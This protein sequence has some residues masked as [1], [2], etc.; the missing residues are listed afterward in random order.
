VA[1]R[2]TDS[3]EADVTL[4]TPTRDRPLA[5]SYCERWVARQDFPG[6]V[7]W[8]VVDDGDAPIRTTLG[9]LHVRRKPS[10]AR[11][12]LP[13]NVL[14]AL[15][16]V[17]GAGLVVIEDDD[18]YHPAYVGE[19]VKR[20]KGGAEAVGTTDSL[21]YHVPS[22]RYHNHHQKE[23]ASFC[24]TAAAGKVGLRNLKESVLLLAGSDNPLVDMEFWSPRRTMRRDLFAGNHLVCGLKGWPGRR[25][26]CPSSSLGP[27]FPR[28][29]EGAVL[30]RWIGEEDAAA[31]LAEFSRLPW[32][33][34]EQQSTP[35]RGGRGLVIAAWGGPRRVPD[36]AYDA[37]RGR[38]LRLWADALTR[39]SHALD[40]VLVVVSN[41]PP[42]PKFEEG[43]EQV[44]AASPRARV[45]RRSNRGMSYGA[46]SDAFGLRGDADAAAA[47]QIDLWYLFED[48]WVPCLN[49]WDSE[50]ARVYASKPCAFMGSMVRTDGRFPDH[51]G[52]GWGLTSRDSLKRVWRAQGRLPHS[53]RA[54]YSSC[55]VQGNVGLYVAL[56]EAT[57]LPLRD[58]RGS[59]RSAYVKPWGE[60]EWSFTEQDR[61]IVLPA[62]AVQGDFLTPQAVARA[63]RGG[64]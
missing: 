59:Y 57:G 14:A 52:V 27:G 42:E 36:P 61:A 10:S 12:T 47:R 39:F 16:H 4:F 55:E 64:F 37:D 32:A 20:L 25:N 5:F 26:L 18:W 11:N 33:P 44:R 43:L 49:G 60:V 23:H 29:D 40:D 54:D 1:V 21:Y 53:P 34:E 6:T 9:Q 2:I 41:G 24:S 45:L 63:E 8:V 28:D 17:V 30:A 15:P 50:L 58:V 22:R 62:Q 46:W 56:R 13:E 3:A 31:V 35:P 51:I 7:R 38:Y 19:M 48:D